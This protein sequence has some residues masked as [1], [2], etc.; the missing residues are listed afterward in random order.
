MAQENSGAVRLYGLLDSL[1]ALRL[2]YSDG[3]EGEAALAVLG[4]AKVHEV[5]TVLDSAI[6][7]TKRI[8]AEV[9]PPI[10]PR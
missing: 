10:P 3:V 4:E 6:R 8:I 5:R 7:M 1:V 9:D 2:E